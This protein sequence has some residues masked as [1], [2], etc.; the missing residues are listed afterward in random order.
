MTIESY[1]W[2]LGLV[3]FLSVHQLPVCQLSESYRWYLGLVDFIISPSTV[4][5]PVKWELSLVFRFW[6]ILSEHQL[7]ACPLSES[8]RWCLG[9]VDVIST[10]TACQLS[11]SY[12]WCLDFGGFYQVL[13]L[14][15]TTQ[16][17]RLVELISTSIACMV[18]EK[19]HWRFRLVHFIKVLIAWRLRVIAGWR[20]T[21]LVSLLLGLLCI[22]NCLRLTPNARF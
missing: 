11:Y 6:W 18:S 19:Y 7:P 15:E 2:Y 1:R 5:M 10:S 9:L 17:F 13:Q 8:C 3:D 14:T 22:L 16:Q 12:R 20:S 4:C 21:S